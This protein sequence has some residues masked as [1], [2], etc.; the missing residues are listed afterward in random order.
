MRD[1][2][3]SIMLFAAGFGTRMG[4]LTAE[5]PKPMVPV[6][7]RPLVDHALDQVIPMGFETVVANLHYKPEALA[8][9][10]SKRGIILS[11]ESP[12][13]LETGGG[14]RAALSH[15]GT[16]PVFTMNTDAI[17]IGPNPLQALLQ[18]WEQDRMDALL[19][20]VSPDNAVGHSGTG[21]F[22]LSR[23]GRLSRGKGLI[24]SGAQIIKTDLLH[25]I[26]K[27][28]FSLNI[29]WEE[30]LKQQRLFGLEYHGAWCDVGQPESIPL[31]E[32]ALKA[33][34]V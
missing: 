32:R 26:R 1:T 8:A 9:H 3:T 4:N 20:C 10:L 28:A 23:S 22:L 18:A 27:T 34:N 30:M 14:L 12:D 16:R 24:Y 17:W 15:L 19:L 25:D 13:I 6:A 11:L 7:G 33:H 21:D 29:V 5:Q 31:A 2:P